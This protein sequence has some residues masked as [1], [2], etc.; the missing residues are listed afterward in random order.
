MATSQKLLKTPDRAKQTAL[1]NPFG[2][3]FFVPS[4]A[5]IRGALGKGTEGTAS[6]LTDPAPP[7]VDRFSK[8]CSAVQRAGSI[9]IRSRPE[10]A[11]HWQQGAQE[12]QAEP[13]ESEQKELRKAPKGSDPPSVTFR[14]RT[15]TAL[16]ALAPETPTAKSKAHSHTEFGEAGP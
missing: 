16:H 10:P 7:S 8:L 6:Q 2:A 13:E 3:G 12:G 14:K 4:S 15:S 11:D 9:R 1:P 5:V